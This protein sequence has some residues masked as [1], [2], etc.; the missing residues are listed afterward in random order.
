MKLTVGDRF[1]LLKLLPVQSDAVTIGLI[2]DVKKRLLLTEAEVAYFGYKVVQ[3]DDQQ[4]IKWTKPEE[5]VEI[6]IGQVVTN[7]IV[8]ILKELNEEK[9][10]TEKTLSLHN[11]FV[12]GIV[13]SE[14]TLEPTV[15]A[16]QEKEV[17][18]V[19]AEEGAPTA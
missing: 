10:I 4:S 17:E 5:E 15:D 18:A 14:S 9:E 7:E 16:V 19:Q 11:K 3:T 8:K 6:E 1:A 2:A 13:T 12:E